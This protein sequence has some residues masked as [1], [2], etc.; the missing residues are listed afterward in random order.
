MLCR[1]C[2]AWEIF[3]SNASSHMRAP[4]QHELRW[5]AHGCGVATG[6]GGT[7]TMII[8]RGVTAKKI[9]KP[10]VELL[11]K[12]ASAITTGVD[13]RGVPIVDV[14]TGRMAMPKQKNSNSQYM[15]LQEMS[16]DY[17]IPESTLR[18]AIRTK[19]LRAKKDGRR[20]RIKRTDA[21]LYVDGLPEA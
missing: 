15:T 2:G 13:V 12:D 20:I 14:Q 16:A 18:K 8:V 5:P 4:T 6:K 3:D 1:E 7:A 10:D 17:G 19:K 9:W 11:A 21:A